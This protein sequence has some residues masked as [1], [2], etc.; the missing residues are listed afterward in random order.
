[1]TVGEEDASGVEWTEFPFVGLELR[2]LCAKLFPTLE[3]SGRPTA[4]P[5]SR[6]GQLGDAV[7]SIRE[8]SAR[9]R[10][11]APVRHSSRICGASWHCTCNPCSR[12]T[13]S[14]CRAGGRAVE[15]GRARSM[16][17][18]LFLRQSDS[19]RGV[20]GLLPSAV[21]SDVEGR[22]RVS[23]SVREALNADPELRPRQRDAN[24]VAWHLDPTAD[25]WAFLQ[26]ELHGPFAFAAT[27]EAYAAA[28]PACE[29]RLR[30]YTR[31]D[32]AHA[33]PTEVL[34]A[35]PRGVAGS[36]HAVVVLELFCSSGADCVGYHYDPVVASPFLEG[37]TFVGSDGRFS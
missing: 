37:R 12:R 7:D 27:C 3:I 24:G 33:C 9:P 20:G 15:S 13:S 1:M 36:D 6:D 34:L 30:V 35:P 2:P 10:P 23:A 22:R 19:G 8:A 32:R 21:G 17:E 14:V 18:R 11:S 5:G 4:A 25:R 29:V 16:G 26:A 28:Q 31:A